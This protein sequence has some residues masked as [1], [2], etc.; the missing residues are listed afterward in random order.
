MYSF[1]KKP[2]P[3]VQE[4]LVYSFHG[5]ESRFPAGELMH[6]QHQASTGAVLKFLQVTI[7]RTNKCSNLLEMY[8]NLVEIQT[9]KYVFLAQFKRTSVC[10]SISNVN[11]A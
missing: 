2:F 6:L 3:F 8:T 4:R 5:H 1:K 9:A 11:N 7:F 10:N